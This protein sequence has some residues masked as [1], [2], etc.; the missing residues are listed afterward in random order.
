MSCDLLGF[1]WFRAR[2]Y[3]KRL[4]RYFLSLVISLSFA[5][6]GRKTTQNDG[7]NLNFSNMELLD[8][9]GP[10]QHTI[11]NDL[12]KISPSGE[13]ISSK[14]VCFSTFNVVIPSNRLHQSIFQAILH[15]YSPSSLYF[16]PKFI[17]RQCQEVY[18]FFPCNAMFWSQNKRALA[19]ATDC[20][21]PMR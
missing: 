12:C 11:L 18:N 8:H 4:A 3:R 14:I 13:G 2:Q 15:M 10:C 21:W 19:K 7:K 16:H 5:C 17:V 6:D 20:R 1:P 9:A